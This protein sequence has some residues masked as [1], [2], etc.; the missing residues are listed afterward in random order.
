MLQKAC[1]GTII[2]ICLLYTCH[3]CVITRL[4]GGIR[5]FRL[6]RLFWRPYFEAVR[7][8][9]SVTVENRL[10]SSVSKKLVVSIS[11]LSTVEESYEWPWCLLWPLV[12]GG[13]ETYKK[14]MNIIFSVHPDDPT[15]NFLTINKRICSRS[16]KNVY[17]IR[18]LS[19]QH[20]LQH[21]YFN[22]YS[23]IM[24]KQHYVKCISNP[25]VLYKSDLNNI[26]H[27]GSLLS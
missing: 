22:Y 13:P 1:H 9:V 15:S 24:T 11:L 27:V 10:S 5:C 20:I 6:C 26:N 8:V 4:I 3:F 21:F 17:W 16:I 14:E 18:L 25:Y 23:T 7:L 2:C 19:L 12:R